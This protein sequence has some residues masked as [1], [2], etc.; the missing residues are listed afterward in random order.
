MKIL[1]TRRGRL[2]TALAMMVAALV[3][4]GL[5]LAHVRIERPQVGTAA[6]RADTLAQAPLPPPPVLPTI[7]APETP[8]DARASNARLP[9]VA[10]PTPAPPFHFAGSEAD[11]AAARACLA[12]A[13]LYE[14]GDDAPGEKA[15][16]Q[17]VLNRVRH[18]VFPKTVCGVIFQGS[19]R[20][21]GCQFTFTCDGSLARAPSPAGWTRAVKIA[22]AALDGT[23]DKSVGTAT[24]YHADYVVP[25]WRATLEKIAVVHTQIFYRWPGTW[26]SKG[27]LTARNQ[28][29]EATGA[30]VAELAGLGIEGA[31]VPL[32]AAPASAPSLEVEGVA[33]ATLAGTT[34]RMKDE[35]AGQFVLQLSPNAPPG[36][37]ATAAASLCGEKLECAVYGWM[38]A[39]ELPGSLPVTPDALRTL[40]F[41]YR[42]SRSLGL[43]QPYWDC[44]RFPRASPSQ[45]LTD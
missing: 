29:G 17:V 14:A 27:V 13:V 8:D 5:V 42:K 39:A 3:A 22:E 10:K 26:G 44:R 24:H 18:P 37:F 6:P 15:V 31:A 20:K 12:T 33:P 21:T 19:E 2:A 43:A 9:I 7:L 4:V 38:S 45:C 30:R 1:G 23:V 28:P 35:D 34:L 11:R 25:Y 40:A 36:S 41:A 16:A 32:G